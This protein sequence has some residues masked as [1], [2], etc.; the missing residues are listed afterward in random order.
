LLSAKE[1]VMM[2]VKNGAQALKLNSGSLEKDKFADII[3][4]GLDK[5]HLTP[6]YDPYSHLVYCANAADVDN[7]IINGRVLMRSRKVL[8][9]D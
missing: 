9:L 8:G 5:P 2:T 1:I 6:M 3:T 4:I 7:V